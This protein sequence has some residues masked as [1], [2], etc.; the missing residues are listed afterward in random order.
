VKLHWVVFV[1]LVGW[2]G[3]SAFA[4]TSAPPRMSPIKGGTD[5]FID[6]ST[7]VSKRQREL[8]ESGLTTFSRLEVRKL[9]ANGSLEGEP[10]VKMNCT[11]RYDLWRESFEVIQM[12]EQ[13]KP[14]ASKDFAEFSKHCLQVKLEEA[15]VQKDGGVP[16]GLVA[17]LFVDQVSVER[18]EKIR[19]WLIKQQSGVM[20]S[21]FSHMLG[22]LKLSE[23]VDV[24]V[25]LNH[26]VS[27]KVNSK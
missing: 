24:Y 3:A 18:A 10:L 14:S 6:V 21:V 8:F 25:Q 23:R 5:W 26:Q 4:E 20:Q 17:S 11:A 16:H 15:V 9:N 2:L 27:T 22:D 7:F 1:S 19:E 12:L 13:P